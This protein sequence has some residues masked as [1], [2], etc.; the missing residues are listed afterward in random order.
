MMKPIHAMRTL[1]Q[2][3][4][5]LVAGRGRGGLLGFWPASRGRQGAAAAGALVGVRVAGGSLLVLALA[6]APAM[7]QAPVRLTLAE[8]L[9]RAEAASETVAIAEAGV[10]RARGESQQAR[11]GLL[12]S[13]GATVGY[14]R[15]LE[16]EYEALSGASPDTGSNPF[17][18]MKLP[19][20]QANR[21]D[22]GV[23]ASQ[24]VFAGGRVRARNRIAGSGRRHAE[25]GLVSARAQL[26]LDVTRA[27]YDASL[28]DRLAS[29]A[30]ASLAQAEQTLAHVQAGQRV[31]E[32][33]EFDAL[34][35][36]VARDNQRPQVIQRRT[37]RDLA[38]MRLKQLVNL[39]DADSVVLVV[40]GSDLVADGGHGAAP[41]AAARAGS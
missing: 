4:G 13:V 7:A 36:Q 6:A 29:I 24:T 23:S 3:A 35:A 10:L 18:G 34:R 22:L 16:S 39:G 8:A 31:G 33:A 25:I 12:P 5:M 2:V 1:L 41:D 30:E 11:S 14:A 38:Y 17:A 32:R 15:T 9:A 37:D 26:A 21:Y 19:F 27:F 20:G 40:P 28:S